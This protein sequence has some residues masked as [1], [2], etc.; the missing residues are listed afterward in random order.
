M[1]TYT[2]FS[3]RRKTCANNV[4]VCH[5]VSMAGT[6]LNIMDLEKRSHKLSGVLDE[7]SA[8]VVAARSLA[9]KMEDIAKEAR[10]LDEEKEMLR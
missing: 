5:T 3:E 9:S 10:K 8:G 4:F 2:R 1:L 6:M 7:G